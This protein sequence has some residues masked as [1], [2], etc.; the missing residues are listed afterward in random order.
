MLVGGRNLASK[1]RKLALSELLHLRLLLAWL[2]LLRFYY[3]EQNQTHT[4][5]MHKSKSLAVGLLLGGL[6]MTT[7]LVAQA[8]EEEA[9][10]QPFNI[11]VEG[12]TLGLGGSVSWRFADHF[13]VRGGINYFSYSDNENIEGTQYDADLQLQSFPLGF[14]IYPSRSSSFRVTL[15][16]LLNQN[17]LEGQTPLGQ[18]VELNGNTYVDAS[19]ALRLQAEQEPISPYIAIGGNL[20]F[21][22]A[23]HWSLGYELGVAYTGEP[24]VTLTRTGAANPG[25]DA[26]MEAERQ[27]LE[28][29]FSDFK[30]YPIVKV[31]VNFAF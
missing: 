1:R 6:T 14:D 7:A 11:G 21:D 10:Y 26:D 28:D 24:E 3:V 29:K 9:D 22:K 30:L 5:I 17:E 12:G 13:G 20:Y 15:G 27:Q 23:K 16:I 31:S 2:W 8:E 4:M 25:L 19:L 18:P